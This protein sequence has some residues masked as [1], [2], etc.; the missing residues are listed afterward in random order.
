MATKKEVIK[1]FKLPKGKVTIKPVVKSTYLIP[2]TT[3]RA[4]FLV[5][6]AKREYPAPVLRSGQFANVL[7][8]EEKEFFESPEAGLDFRTGDLSIYKRENN[9]W[10]SFKVQLSKEELTLDKSD[11]FQYLQYKV[12]L[13]NNE[14]IASSLEELKSKRKATYKYV[15]VD[16]N[17][18]A[19]IAAKEADL[20]EA[21]WSIYSELKHDR[22]RT[23]D[24]LR[25]F[26]KRVSEESSDDML[27]SLLKTVMKDDTRE[28]VTI[29]SDSNLDMKIFISKCVSAGL[30]QKRGSSYRIPE[31][32]ILGD[33]LFSAA[34]YLNKPENQEILL[35]LQARL[36][37]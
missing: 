24:I 15:M 37:D 5:D 10:E 4:A 36:N 27:R 28:F 31:G 17:Q 13:A 34:V 12:L 3:H 11:P 16:E 25:I 18:E 30:L 19:S 23:I 1:E 32:E 33:T 9:F 26:N 2:D 8:D 22:T 14:E 29:V 21:A 6:G 7:T 20:E 35:S